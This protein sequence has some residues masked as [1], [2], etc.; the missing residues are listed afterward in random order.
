[1]LFLL[2]LFTAAGIIILYGIVCSRSTLNPVEL[3]Q[4]FPISLDHFYAT[5]NSSAETLLILKKFVQIGSCL[6]N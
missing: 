1:M 2:D 4:S 3:G 5:H 6:I